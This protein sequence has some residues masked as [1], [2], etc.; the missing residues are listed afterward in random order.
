MEQQI[1]IPIERAVNSVPYVINRRSRTIFG[2]SIVSLTFKEGTDD[3]FA[4]QQVLEKLKEAQLPDSVEP[5]LGPLTS[6]IGEILRYIVESDEKTPMELRELQDWVITPKILQA[7][8]V[9]DIANFGGL[10]RRFYVVIDPMR[11]DKYKLTIQNVSDAITLN[12][13]STGGS[14][15]SHGASQLAIRSIGRVTKRED[16]ENIVVTAQKGVPVLVKDVASVEI[17]SLP[18]T[19]ILGYTDNLRKKSN[20][21]SVEGI[22]LMRRGENPSET[23][24]SIKEKIDE[25]NGGLLPKGVKIVICYDR[26][27]LIDGTL[28][29]VGKTLFEGVSIVMVILF[30]LGNIRAAIS[31]AIMI[32]LSLLFAF[33]M[34]KMTNIPANLLSLGGIDFGI[35]VDSAIVVV[36]S[37]SRH[38]S[39]ASADDRKQNLTRIIFNSTSEVQKQ[40]F[41]AVGIIILAYLPLFTLQ[42]VEGKLFTPMAFTF[43]YAVLGSML[44][45]LT[46][47]PVVCSFIFQKIY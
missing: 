37:I 47:V 45:A 7:E 3:Y 21:N 41:F 5:Q 32:P 19:G 29:T 43:A 23:L 33:F 28:R 17:G 16:I 15:I 13:T 9:V 25:L 11:I 10:V 46:A 12:N 14:I 20:D 8:G 1:T 27:D 6:P 30:F 36:E 26:Q 24:E 39:G 38:L 44:L 4:R 35:I 31:V 18:Q 40:I 2:L 34:M 22:V 42:R